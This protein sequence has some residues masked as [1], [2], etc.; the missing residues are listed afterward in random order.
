VGI[1]RIIAAKSTRDATGNEGA[2]IFVPF[3]IHTAT[4]MKQFDKFAMLKG[5][6]YLHMIHAARKHLGQ[7][8]QQRI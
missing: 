8:L 5:D 1:R 2:I 7:L 6:H 4:T 3:D